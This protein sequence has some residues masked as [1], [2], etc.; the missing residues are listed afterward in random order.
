MHVLLAFYCLVF[1]SF[2]QRLEELVNVVRKIRVD[3]ETTAIDIV[4]LG[5]T[6]AVV[7]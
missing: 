6:A 2:A 7:R 3:T 1:H 4:M 5:D